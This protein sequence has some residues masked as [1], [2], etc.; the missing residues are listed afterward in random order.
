MKTEISNLLLNAAVEDSCLSFLGNL[1]QF[2]VQ[3]SLGSLKAL[4]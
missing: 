1:F 3:Q 4:Q 2:Q